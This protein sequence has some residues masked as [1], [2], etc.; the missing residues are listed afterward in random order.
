MVDLTPKHP[1]WQ[2]RVKI[3]I[4]NVAKY[5]KFLQRKGGRSW[6]FLAPNKEPKYNFMKWEGMLVVPSKP[7]IK[8][9]MVI[10]LPGNYPYSCPRAFVEEKIVDYCGKLYLKNIWEEPN[11]EKYVMICHDHMSEVEDAWKPTL[12][13]AHFFIREVFYWW[14]AQQQLVIDEWNRCKKSNDED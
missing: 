13:I 11:G 14:S 3:E 8:F 12:T 10:L 6:F 7:E 9:K 2:E 5:V 4:L 1:K